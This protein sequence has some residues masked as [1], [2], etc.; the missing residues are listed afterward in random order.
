MKVSEYFFSVQGEG[1]SAGV[2]SLFI[3]FPGCNLLCG[4]HM[5][6]LMKEGKATWYCDTEPLWMT[7]KEVTPREI[8]DSLSGVQIEAL[9]DQRAHVVFTGG[10]PCMSVNTKYA[11]EFLTYFGGSGW[12]FIEVETNGTLI[13]DLLD[14]THQINCS[15][16]LSNSGM[17]RAMRIRPDVLK[18]IN[19][20]GG[21]AAQFKFVVSTSG[22]IQEVMGEFVVPGYVPIEKVVLMPGVDNRADMAERT[23]FVWEASQTLGIRMCTR[24][25][26]L[27][28]DRVTGV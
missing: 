12:P 17:P 22:D 27:A 6:K 28:F 3:R 7:S 8:V 14:H 10:E 2:P 16:K 20:V 19:D 9:K 24:L 25:H 4:G 21:R 26:V 1:I 13:S 15:P 18:Y 5:G 23:R 11:E